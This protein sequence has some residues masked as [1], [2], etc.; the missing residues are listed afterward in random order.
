MQAICKCNRDE[1]LKEMKQMTLEEARLYEKNQGFC[2]RN[3]RYSMS[4]HGLAG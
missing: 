4:L 1:V 2:R 3:V